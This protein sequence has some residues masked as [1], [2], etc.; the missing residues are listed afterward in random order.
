MSHLNL[1]EQLRLSFKGDTMSLF[2]H[3]VFDDEF[4]DKF[5]SLASFDS[6]R[7]VKGRIA[8]VLAE[9]FQ[10]VIR[11]KDEVL[12]GANN[13]TF[14]VRGKGNWMHIFSS[15]LVDPEVKDYLEGRLR[16]I[17]AFDDEE[18]KDAYLEILEKGELSAKGGAGLG[19]I[20]MARRSR[21]PIQYE[22]KEREQ[23]SFAFNMQVDFQKILSEE[24]V[25]N[26]TIL[27][28]SE[29]NE[30]ILKENILFIYNGE[31]SDEV[32]KPIIPIMETNA[33]EGSAGFSVFHI[34]VELMQNIGRHGVP[35]EEGQK[36]GLFALKK[37]PDGYYICSGNYTDADLDDLESY[38][39]DL[40]NRDAENLNEL[41]KTAL[42][43]SVTTDVNSAKVGMIDIK[44]TANNPIDIKIV[45]DSIGKYLMLG[46]KVSV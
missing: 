11:H 36:M 46:V 19:L 40:N 20:E 17:N 1:L 15:N 29:L 25:H 34:A 16:N 6:E 24:N 3:G 7:K 37:L 21:N 33:D 35:N 43:E 38:V 42:K 12:D 41:Y 13:N 27:Q 22:F 5:I 28:D 39:Q 30:L 32:L 45:E 26:V 44:R 14:G 8:F 10:N 31:F 18:L 23:G 4:T 9:S 2:Y